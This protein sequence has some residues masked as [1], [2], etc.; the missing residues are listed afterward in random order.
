MELSLSELICS[1]IKVGCLFSKNHYQAL[2]LK[3]LLRGIM[4]QVRRMEN[5]LFESNPNSI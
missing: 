4:Y 3:I 1:K 2:F 5:I